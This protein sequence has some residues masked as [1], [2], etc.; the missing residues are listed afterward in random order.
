MKVKD[1]YKL[2]KPSYDDLDKEF[3]ISTIEETNFPIKEIRKKIA[4]VFESYV[5][6]I[7]SLLQ[8]ESDIIALHEYNYITEKDRKEL[9]EIFRKLMYYIRY[10]NEL[11]LDGMRNEDFIKKAYND[12]ISMKPRL[13]TVFAKV[14]ESWNKQIK[15]SEEIGYLG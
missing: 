7:E 9:H 4:E 13:K 5:K 15:S 3:E 2:E 12:W 1:A 10:S 8:P 11:S 6:V 14:K